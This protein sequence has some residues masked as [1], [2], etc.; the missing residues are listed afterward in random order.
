MVKGKIGAIYFCPQCAGMELYVLDNTF[1]NL[2]NEYI[3]YD[4][5]LKFKISRI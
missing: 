4:C 2:K 1:E 3:C 5:K